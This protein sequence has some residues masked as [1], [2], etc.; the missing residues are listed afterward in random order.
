MKNHKCHVTQ[1]F[2]DFAPSVAFNII[3]M[4]QYFL[5]RT[6]VKMYYPVFVI[7]AKFSVSS[8]LASLLV[9][10]RQGCAVPTH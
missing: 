5:V 10:S 8:N 9:N 3:Y 1:T 6:T 7:F 4:Y 2:Q